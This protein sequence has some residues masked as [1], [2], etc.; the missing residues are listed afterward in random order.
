MSPL[1]TVVFLIIALVVL[2]PYL[3]RIF[4]P[5]VTLPIAPPTPGI[6]TVITSTLDFSDAL[7][8]YEKVATTAIHASEQAV[9]LSNW[10]IGIVAGLER[11]PYAC[12]L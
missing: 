5:P 6:T 1:L 8:T 11:F 4:P 3:L 10:L 2:L 12:T 9:A 7:S